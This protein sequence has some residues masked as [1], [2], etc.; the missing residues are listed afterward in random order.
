MADVSNNWIHIIFVS[1]IYQK[2][3]A[4][5]IVSAKHSLNKKRTFFIGNYY[6]EEM[7]WKDIPVWLM[8]SQL[9]NVCFVWNSPLWEFSHINA[10]KMWNEDKKSLSPYN[11]KKKLQLKTKSILQE[12]RYLHKTAWFFSKT[13][14]FSNV[15]QEDMRNNWSLFL[16]ISMIDSDRGKRV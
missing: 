13:S 15:T 10:S 2:L 16:D 9:S 11:Y 14:T 3:V 12:I 1:S 8:G 5:Q 6:I 4:A 7:E